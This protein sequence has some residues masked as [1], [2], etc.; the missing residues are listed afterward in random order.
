MLRL[1]P[2]LLIEETELAKSDVLPNYQL[3][4]FTTMV[5]HACKQIPVTVRQGERAVL[6]RELK[7]MTELAHPQLLLL[8]GYTARL[9]LVYEPVLLGSLYICL[10]I[11]SIPFR[12]E[13]IALQ[14]TDALI[15]LEDRDVVHR[16]VSSHAVQVTTLAGQVKL[17]MLEAAVRAGQHAM[18][19]LDTKLYNW[20]GPELLASQHCQARVES[21]VYGLCCLIWEMV[22]NQVP[23]AGK[24]AADIL[25]E[26]GERKSS[27]PLEREWMPVLVFRTLRQGLVW[28]VDRRDLDLGEIRD[29]MFLSREQQDKLFFARQP[30]DKELLSRQANS[31]KFSSGPS[32]K[33]ER[34]QSNINFSELCDV[35]KSAIQTD[36]VKY[37]QDSDIS[38]DEVETHP[39][40]KCGDFRSLPL[41]LDEKPKEVLNSM[42]D[43]SLVPTIPESCSAD[44]SK[45]MF[46]GKTGAHLG[47]KPVHPISE[48]K[49]V[50][51]L[52]FGV[53]T[54]SSAPNLRGKS[55]LISSEKQVP[56]G[57]YLK[58][59]RGNREQSP[60]RTESRKAAKM[61]DGRLREEEEP[62]GPDCSGRVRNSV[63]Y[64]ESLISLSD[65][66][67]QDHFH[68]A[69]E[70]ETRQ[71][72]NEAG[73][74]QKEELDEEENPLNSTIEK[75]MLGL[76]DNII[77]E[78]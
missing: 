45:E 23:W 1:N 61:K 70:L 51:P 59:W 4:S 46:G 8:M 2:R 76:P 39:K 43:E 30:V 73:N 12:L 11:H 56:S 57:L 27:L 41:L 13:D 65:S 35:A 16:V 36:I 10:Y 47:K 74:E 26:V 28:E 18:R 17:G 54:T 6:M 5:S 34:R 66:L 14:V 9:E 55:Q 37:L 50:K 60:R 22:H 31:K 77:V 71:E 40:P 48:Q 68:S 19:P 75:L 78:T 62:T 3:G 25:S 72:G 44:N 20:L 38:E 29:M 32:M 7:M 33:L 53:K 21:D 24:S 49:E 15:Y 63:R 64:F 52:R 67:G 58:L 69:L 42:T